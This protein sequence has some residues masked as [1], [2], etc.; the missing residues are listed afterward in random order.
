M[1]T[2]TTPI[3]LTRLEAKCRDMA[4]VCELAHDRTVRECRAAR[5]KVNCYDTK[6]CGD[7]NQLHGKE[8]EGMT[9]YTAKAQAI[10]DSHYDHITEVTGL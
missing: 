5:I 1:T 10:F 3:K 9:H 4:D 7:E 8:A 2:T 6:D